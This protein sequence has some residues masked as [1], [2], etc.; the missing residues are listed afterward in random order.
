MFV[1]TQPLTGL[2]KEKEKEAKGPYDIPE[3]VLTISKENTYPNSVEDQEIVE[4]STLTKTLIDEMD[5]PIENADL[6]KMLNETSLKPSPIAIGYRGTVYLGRWALNYKS[7]ASAV[8]WEYQ[9]VNLNELNNISGEQILTM[10]YN[11]EAEKEVQGAL[12]SKIKN[13][14][15]IKQM[16]LLQAKKK[17]E[18]PLSFQTIIGKDTKKDNSYNIPVKKYGYLKAHAPAVNEKGEVTFGE[19]YI[20]LKGSKKSIIV[21]NVTKQGIG[22]WIPVQDH[23][24]FSFQLK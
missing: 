11:Q 15:D 10:H 16:M 20:E 23:L 19:V 21:K 6:I 4:P 22:A 7:L 2:A 18:L 17:T 12:T 8:N 14:E 1:L 5:I 24:S 13:P 9:E 3:H